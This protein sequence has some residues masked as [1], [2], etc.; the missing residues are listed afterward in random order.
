MLLAYYYVV[1]LAN[2]GA[3]G[4]RAGVSGEHHIVAHT[5]INVLLGQPVLGGDIRHA[6][7]RVIDLLNISVRRIFI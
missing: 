2:V 5:F 3:H 7:L 6:Q 1:G 4:T